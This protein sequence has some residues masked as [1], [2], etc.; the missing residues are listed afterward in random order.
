MI[1]K[2]LTC[3]AICS[4]SVCINAQISDGTHFKQGMK[5][6]TS[7]NYVEAVTHFQA[8]SKE[9]YK[10]DPLSFAHSLY[11]IGYT[12]D[13]LNKNKLTE[14]YYDSAY[15]FVKRNNVKDTAQFVEISA[16]FGL[17]TQL[18]YKNEHEEAGKLMNDLRH[19]IGD[20]PSKSKF[21][22]NI[23]AYLDQYMTR[24]ML[25]TG[26]IDSAFYY[27][28]RA[29]AS[30]SM[31]DLPYILGE[32]YNVNAEYF[33]M[34]GNLTESHKNILKQYNLY[35][36]VYGESDQ[37]TMRPTMHLGLVAYQTGD[38]AES[39]KYLKK[40]YLDY[41]NRGDTSSI[42]Y[43]DIVVNLSDCYYRLD[44]KR[45]SLSMIDKCIRLLD[46]IGESKE[47]LYE[48]YGVK[49]AI[50][51]EIGLVDV[52]KAGIVNA[53]KIYSY[54]KAKEYYVQLVNG[55]L[56]EA[57]QW[58]GD[59]VTSERLAHRLLA[60][61]KKTFGKE[62]LESSRTY[63]R[64]AEINFSKKN[65]PLAKAYADSA[66]LANNAN[67]APQ[68]VDIYEFITKLPIDVYGP[69]LMISKIREGTDYLDKLRKTLKGEVSK[70]VLTKSFY[71]NALGILTRMDKDIKDES[72]IF[73]LFEKNKSTQL[74]NYIKE[75][76]LLNT[77]NISEGL[78]ATKTTL[79]NE[80]A[81]LDQKLQKAKGENDTQKTLQLQTQLVALTE[82]YDD[83]KEELKKQYPVYYQI[84][85]DDGVS[86]KALQSVLKKQ[87]QNLITYHMNKDRLYIL[88]VTE[89]QLTIHEA[90]NLDRPIPDMIESFRNSLYNREDITLGSKEFYQLLLAPV[91][92][93]ITKKKLVIIPDELLALVPFEVLTSA[94]DRYV[95][96]DYTI[97]YDYSASTYV[98]SHLAKSYSG[99]NLLAMAPE[100]KG[101]NQ[102]DQLV[103]R[104]GLSA[105]PGANDEALSVSGVFNG[106]S[107]IGD[108]A[109][110]S[111]FKSIASNFNV[112][113][114]ATHAIVDNENSNN[115][116]L[117]FSNLKDSTNDGYMYPYEIYTL[118]LKADLV[119][120]SACNTGFGNLQK[121]EG[122]VS[123]SRAFAYSG[124]AAT[125]MSLWP[126]SDK[127]TPQ[128]M[129][130]FYKYLAE[131][132][133]KDESIR[134]AKLDF[135]RTAKNESR[136]PYFWAGFILNG[137]IKPIE[138]P[139]QWIYYLSGLSL[140]L[141]IALGY[142]FKSSR[143]K[144]ASLR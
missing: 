85:Y 125:I 22:Y 66:F 61:R 106:T 50:A 73:T 11:R 51:A 78:V 20:N 67:N 68:Q 81:I 35:K 71:T 27:V 97:A 75:A 83:F 136:H 102:P 115:S 60:Y 101:T 112:L 127:T 33:F 18:Y 87:G 98:H 58:L 74:L 116:K 114:L 4:A 38:Y 92:A 138:K 48:Y 88:L 29:V 132:N 59:Y 140:F 131:G 141:L 139:S 108:N 80:L 76:E 37:R 117:V 1:H 124:C 111:Q 55:Q 28:Q 42:Y 118:K 126:V 113:H 121:G 89:S 7:G 32:S 107:I 53:E 19:L 143:S 119:T 103:F 39:E 31:T 129:S 57:Y 94:N 9:Y 95:I 110:E 72:L 34:T 128:I 3:L 15:Q 6:H 16:L 109:T 144:V 5:L 52:A 65:M 69:E 130:S 77:L 40:V 13:Q 17:S 8:A 30:G 79:T 14:T 100:F 24:N 99:R 86:L 142:Y 10:T 137:D 46:R 2:L 84:K 23:L 62:S 122:I 41:I 12:Y 49:A 135:L 91:V 56:I 36:K 120:L 82:N 26:R 105:L 134:M 45:E 96:E 90:G 104:N 44:N 133:D 123:L 25:Y 64:L 70:A 63:L 43:S 93:N 21:K 47:E 54:K